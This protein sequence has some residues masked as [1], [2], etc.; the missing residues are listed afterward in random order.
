MAEG[1]Y[2]LHNTACNAEIQFVD[3]PLKDSNCPICLELLK[4]PFLTECC[5]HHFCNKCVTSVQLQKNEC[6]LCK[7]SPIRGII[8][9][10]FRREMNEAQVYC[11][12][13]PQGCEWIGELGN[14]LVHL[15][16]GQQYGQC[17]YLIVSCPNDK[18]DKRLPRHQIRTHESRECNY[19]PYTCPHC[20]LKDVFLFIEQHHFSECPNY[21]VACPNNCMKTK[22]KRSQLQ[23]HS[24]VCPNAMIPCCFSEV[25]CKVKLKRC[26]VK[27]HNETNFGQ[28][29][30]LVSVAITELK[31]ESTIMKDKC[32]L[33][34][35]ELSIQLDSK[36]SIL[37]R[38]CFD[39]VHKET[40]KEAKLVEE[41]G[42]VV[43]VYYKELKDELS[44][45]Q[46]ENQKLRSSLSSLQSKYSTLESEIME[47]RSTF[48]ATRKENKQ[49]K[50]SVESLQSR[51]YPLE[52]QVGE[53]RTQLTVVQSEMKRTAFQNHQQVDPSEIQQLSTHSIDSWINCYKQIADKMKRLNWKLYLRTMAETA[54]RFPDP[55]SP[56]IIKSTGYKQGSEEPGYSCRLQTSSFYSA[57]QDKYKFTLAIKF[58]I[59][60]LS[61]LASV[62]RGDYDD[63]LTW[64]FVGSITVTL[65]NQLENTGH[66]S[67][68]IWSI[69]DK[70]SLKYAGRVP[71]NY[72]YNPPFGKQYY[73]SYDVL[74]DSPHR[75]F[76]DDLLY[77]EVYACAHRTK[78]S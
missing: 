8:D 73:I 65:L 20:G 61:I 62:T 12:L 40:E 56:V 48:A 1:T 36:I 59:N 43:P 33:N 6:P 30:M 72:T 35:Q 3:G 31:K 66:Y 42:T 49:L 60:S 37:E 7:T 10:R 50:S 41:L 55:V 2:L 18:C 4:D 70:P 15:S 68:E 52:I 5:G 24:K 76:M 16:L 51:F 23:K 44:A 63:R 19:R 54:T 69:S 58:S 22:I 21:P 27:K 77:F 34:F 46:K 13:R 26:N 78:Y 39:L 25:G 29:Q 64:P 47:L 9:K 67:R 53:L 38:K 57:G 75:Y 17:K 45:T 74:E 32:Q 14:L 11:S 71:P 28:H